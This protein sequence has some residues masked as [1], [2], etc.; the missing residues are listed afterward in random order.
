MRA[1][2]AVFVLVV[3]AFA[4]ARELRATSPRISY[5]CGAFGIDEN[6]WAGNV[7]DQGVTGACWAFAT[8]AYVESA[9]RALT[10]NNMF[11]SVE[12][13]IDGAEL[14]EPSIIKPGYNGGFAEIALEYIEEFGI[15]TE[16]QYPFTNGGDRS[17]VYDPFKTTPI[18]VSNVRQICEGHNMFM[19]IACVRQQLSESPILASVCVNTGSTTFI[20]YDGFIVPDPLCNVTDHAIVITQI[21]PCFADATC[22]TFQNSWGISWGNGGFGTLIITAEDIINNVDTRGI[23]SSLFVADVFEE[24]DDE[25]DE[26]LARDDDDLSVVAIV[27][28]IAAFVAAGASIAVAAVICMRK[29]K[30]YT[31]PAHIGMT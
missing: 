19:R 20:M 2:F 7:R 29:S 13:V 16:Y 17:D 30:S 22:V 28:S 26:E 31:P 15:M 3:A 25:D 14:I 23:L 5:Q 21:E 9:Y 11:L 27:L 4:N 1:A 24:F 18:A 12:Q 8:I 6:P 10:C